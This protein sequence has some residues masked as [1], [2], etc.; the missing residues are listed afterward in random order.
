MPAS[1]G[2]AYRAL[3]PDLL[4]WVHADADGHRAGDIRNICQTPAAARAAR[5][6]TRSSSFS[7]KLLGIPNDRFPITLRDF[8]NYLKAMIGGGPVRIDQRARDLAKLVLRPR[9][10]MMPGPAMIPFEVVTAGLLPPILRSQYGLT[11]GPGQQ[12]A[13]RL[14]VRTLPRLVALTPPVLRVWPLPGRNVRLKATS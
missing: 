11:W 4:L 6:S 9:L 2:G 10:R 7:A 13:F 3:D 1:Q 14:A 5:T 12:R 8:D